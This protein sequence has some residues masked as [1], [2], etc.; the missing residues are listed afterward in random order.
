[1]ESIT[2]NI[3]DYVMVIH[4]NVP[5]IE[6]IT[7]Q[8]LMPFQNPYIIINFKELEELPKTHRQQVR[9]Q[10]KKKKYV[11]LLIINSPLESY[12]YNELRVNQIIFS[13]EQFSSQINIPFF[14]RIPVFVSFIQC[15]KTNLFVDG[16]QNIET[17]YNTTALQYSM[18]GTHIFKSGNTLWRN[19]VERLRLT[20]TSKRKPANMGENQYLFLTKYIERYKRDKSTGQKSIDG[21]R[22][23][24]H[25]HYPSIFVQFLSFWR[26]FEFY[27][28]RAPYV[29]YSSHTKQLTQQEEQTL[30]RLIFS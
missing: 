24:L 29:K 14:V 2:Q 18:L 23:Y 5:D 19:S 21:F 26:W 4:D 16:T 3:H 22:S 13:I 11:A 28:Q 12:R 15:Y 7:R 10:L 9:Q 8:I 30:Q 6:T 20:L 25:T 17:K 1:M 27:R